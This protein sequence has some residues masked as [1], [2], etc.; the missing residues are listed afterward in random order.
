MIVQF[1]F[2][3]ISIIGFTLI[4]NVKGKVAIASAIVGAL[5]WIIYLVSIK[6]NFSLGFSFFL[7]G[8]WVTFGS[9]IIARI[10]KTP[11]TSV[12]IPTLTPL[13]PGGGAYYT[14]FYIVSNNYELAIEKGIQTGVITGAIV[15]GFVTVS[16]SFRLYS[17][18]KN[19]KRRFK[20][21]HNN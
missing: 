16:E 6:M 20:E 9:E 21:N 8:A 15:L 3:I 4:F 5:G 19:R 7:A 13:V 2:S 11:V 18:Y 10:L 14:M 17:S 12:L 1:I